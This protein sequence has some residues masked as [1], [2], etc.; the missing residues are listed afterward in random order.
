MELPYEKR[1][2][3]GDGTDASTIDALRAKIEGMSYYEFYRHVNPG[4]NDFANW[5]RYVLREEQLAQDLEK[6]TSIVETVELLRDHEHP[7][8]L[9]DMHDDLQR[10][11]EEDSLGVHTPLDVDN[12]MPARA[13]ATPMPA[14]AALEPTPGGMASADATG[15]AGSQATTVRGEPSAAA[16]AARTLSEHDY[17]RLIVKDFMYGLVFGLILGLILG[18]IIS[19]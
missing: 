5:A 8:P 12:P 16:F 6:V 7:L 10:R 9:G 1:F 18:R 2:H 19:L 14:P 15:D 3:F 13:A 11:I 17:T 4:K